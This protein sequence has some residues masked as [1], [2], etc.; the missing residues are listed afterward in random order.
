MFS[1]PG[2][3]RLSA[4]WG[5]NWGETPPEHHDTVFLRCVQEYPQP[6]IFFPVTWPN[7]T[8]KNSTTKKKAS[9]YYSFILIF[10]ILSQERKE[11]IQSTRLM[12]F[13]FMLHE[14]Y[15]LNGL[16]WFFSF[17][18]RC[19]LNVAR[20]HKRDGI[21]SCSKQAASTHVIRNY[22]R[23]R[24]NATTRLIVSTQLH[25]ERVNAT[26]RLIVSTQLHAWMCRST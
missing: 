24:V 12:N 21:F 6:M 7:S 23:E 16:R 11:Y 19:R 22:A 8:S 1:C 3:W 14:F 15:F 10:T 5:P 20:H 25:A 17:L 2:A 4:S 9:L 18:P 26:T 13:I